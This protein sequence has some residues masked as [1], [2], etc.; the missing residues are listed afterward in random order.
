MPIYTFRDKSTGA[1]FDRV[2]SIADRDAFVS[3]P[4]FEQVIRAPHIM[5]DIPEYRSPIDGRLIGSRSTRRDD[6]E[7]NNCREWDPADSPTKGQ[8]HNARFAAKWGVPLAEEAR[9]L[10]QNQAFLAGEKT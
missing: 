6:L 5:P 7:R 4:G 1:E 10:P 2:M 8:F 9:D 3:L